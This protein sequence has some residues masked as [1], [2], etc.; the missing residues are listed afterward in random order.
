MSL[1]ITCTVEQRVIF[2][3]SN[4]ERQTD[5]DTCNCYICIVVQYLAGSEVLLFAFTYAL[6]IPTCIVHRKALDEKINKLWPDLPDS[7]S[8]YQELDV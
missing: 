2:G 6:V 5:V 7:C 8:T 3:G 1:G 4:G